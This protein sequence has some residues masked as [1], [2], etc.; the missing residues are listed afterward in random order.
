MKDL[1]KKLKLSVINGKS[2]EVK[3]LLDVKADVNVVDP[4]TGQSLLIL[5]VRHQ[6][7]AVLREICNKNPKTSVKD[8]QGKDVFYYCRLLG[9]MDAGQ[10]KLME[11][12]ISPKSNINEKST[13]LEERLIHEQKKNSQLRIEVLKAKQRQKEKSSEEPIKIRAFRKLIENGLREAFAIAKAIEEERLQKCPDSVDNLIKIITS[14]T[15]TIES[16]LKLDGLSMGINA[17]DMFIRFYRKRGDRVKAANVVKAFAND[18][19]IVD[20]RKLE[21]VSDAL[22]KRYFWQIMCLIIS[23]KTES[24]VVRP[25]PRPGD[26]IFKLSMVIID[27]IVYS[28]SCGENETYSVSFWKKQEI[29]PIEIEKRC[30]M[31]TLSKTD[32]NDAQAI[33][34]TEVKSSKE[35]TSSGLLDFSGIKVQI[36]SNKVE[37]YTQKHTDYQKYGF[38]LA[39]E[40]E[41]KKLG[42]KLNPLAIDPFVHTKEEKHTPRLF[43]SLPKMTE[44]TQS[45]NQPLLA[46]QTVTPEDNNCQCHCII[47]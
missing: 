34:E 2:E 7:L 22:S 26:S 46:N 15:P 20:D 14:L 31:A 21:M 30:V 40:A 43:E 38:Y 11:S 18:Y 35:W 36:G 25:D 32:S 45:I 9:Q 44:T 47:L 42:F 16:R 29:I 6:N 13:I 39:E 23:T 28:I 33:L 1:Q 10:Q 24:K 37:L 27:R 5:A 3:S 19:K 8:N 41:A 17:I 4:K 12:I